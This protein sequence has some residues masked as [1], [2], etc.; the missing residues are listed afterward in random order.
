M[1]STEIVFHL[2][3]AILAVMAKQNTWSNLNSKIYLPQQDVVIMVR[4]IIDTFLWIIFI[5]IL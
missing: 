1:L 2:K 5:F 4:K 3:I